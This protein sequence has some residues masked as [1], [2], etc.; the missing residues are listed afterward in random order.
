[1][2]VNRLSSEWTA[3]NDNMGLIGLLFNFNHLVSHTSYKDFRV[4][5]VEG[6]AGR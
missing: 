4:S 6:I 3:N 1:M 5:K 2:G